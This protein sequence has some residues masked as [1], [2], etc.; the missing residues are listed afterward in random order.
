MRSRNRL[1]GNKESR[2]KALPHPKTKHDVSI[3]PCYGAPVVSASFGCITIEAVFAASRVTRPN[4]RILIHMKML[5]S[6]R[7]QRARALTGGR[8]RNCRVKPAVQVNCQRGRK[9]SLQFIETTIESCDYAEMLY[10]V[11]HS[12]TL[13]LSEIGQA[14][15]GR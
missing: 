15:Q 3:V 12:A 8:E 5:V 6:V 11:E 13:E 9:V 10:S 4:T 14:V 7:G 2:N 1:P